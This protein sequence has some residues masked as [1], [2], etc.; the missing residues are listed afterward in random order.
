[1][2]EMVR[3]FTLSQW[4]D[5]I[6]QYAMKLRSSSDSAGKGIPDELNAINVS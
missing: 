5:L 3:S 1:V 4:S 6:R 2:S